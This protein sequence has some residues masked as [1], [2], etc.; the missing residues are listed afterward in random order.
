[1]VWFRYGVPA[2]L[3]LLLGRLVVFVL[4][5]T[6]V[7]PGVDLANALEE[8][9]SVICSVIAVLVGSFGSWRWRFAI[10]FLFV[11][12]W[13][14]VWWFGLVWACS[15]DFVLRV[16]VRFTRLRLWWLICF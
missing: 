11:V 6:V 7:D 4:L 12:V 15:V 10:L 9:L 16:G 1:M 2:G 3:R 5:L 14:A 13:V 8:V